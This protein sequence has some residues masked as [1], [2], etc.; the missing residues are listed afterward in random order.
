MAQNTLNQTSESATSQPPE[1]QTHYDIDF[2]LLDPAIVSQVRSEYLAS[3]SN[4][5]ESL[6][7][8][9]DDNHNIEAAK[10][11]TPEVLVKLSQLAKDTDLLAVLRE[12]QQEQ[13]RFYIHI[14]Y[15]VVR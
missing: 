13:V 1:L 6:V 5:K 4:A 11:I 2:S 10:S 8:V 15:L 7:G 14:L 3:M 9:D 12:M